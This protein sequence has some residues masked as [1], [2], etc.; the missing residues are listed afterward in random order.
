MFENIKQAIKDIPPMSKGRYQQ[1]YDKMEDP[2]K[3]TLP[4]THFGKVAAVR[5]VSEL[6]GS[7]CAL[8]SVAVLDKVAPNQMKAL[9]NVVAKT[10][11]RPCLGT[12]EATLDTVMQGFKSAGHDKWREETPPDERAFSYA[13]SIV[14]T[15]LIM[16]PTAYIAQ[17]VGQRGME[18]LLKV[19]E[20]D[21]LS[22][23]GPDYLTQIASMGLLNTVALKPSFQMQDALAE[24]MKGWGIDDERAREN[25]RFFVNFT[26]PNFL[27]AGV[28]LA[29]NH[30]ILKNLK[31]IHETAS[32]VIG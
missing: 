10:I 16:I 13:K 4:K 5:I 31:E 15:G 1:I 9:D 21:F 19:A 23:K 27:G 32:Q 12:I 24:E 14:D 22:I 2:Q 30:T 28:G 7:A 25:A 6:A 26:I 20:V 17:Y 11:V 18:R 3:Q 29:K 8:G